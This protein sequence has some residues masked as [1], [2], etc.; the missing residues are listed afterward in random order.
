MPTHPEAVR[1]NL[2]YYRKQAKARLKAAREADSA[3]PMKLAD[4]QFAIARE[5]GF[6][7]WTRFRDFIVRSKLDFQKLADQFLEAAVSNRR[8]AEEILQQQPEIAAAGLYP[9]LVLGEAA[10]VERALAQTADLAKL[11]GGPHRWEPLLYVCFSR[12]D[13]PRLAE[14]AKVLLRHGADPNASFYAD[15]WPESPL[16]CLYGATGASNN[17]DLALAL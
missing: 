17:P 9:A 14:T 10:R 13:K 5:N 8:R 7:S 15:G 11:K 12:F 16:S 4:A 3:T 1:L 2:E 6:A